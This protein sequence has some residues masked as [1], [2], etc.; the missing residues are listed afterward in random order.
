ME[1]NI[2]TLSFLSLTEVPPGS[3]AC[4]RPPYSAE[5]DILVECDD[6]TS[7]A[8][9]ISQDIVPGYTP[10][11]VPVVLPA[12]GPRVCLVTGKLTVAFSDGMKISSRSTKRLCVV[13]SVS[14]DAG[15]KVPRLDLRIVD[16]DLIVGRVHPGDQTSFRFCLENNDPK[17]T[18]RGTLD[19]LS[20]NN[21]RRPADESDEPPAP[22]HGVFAISD[23]GEGDDFPLAFRDDLGPDC[24]RLPAEPHNTIRPTIARDIVLGPGEKEIVEIVM[25]PWG[26]CANGSCGELLLTLDGIYSDDTDALA[27]S[28]AIIAADTETDPRYVWPDSGKVASLQSTRTG[29]QFLAEP[30]PDESY[31]ILFEQVSLAIGHNGEPVPFDASTQP[32]PL[33]PEHG[34][35]A[36]TVDVEP[37]GHMF[38]SFFDIDVECRGQASAGFETELISMDLVGELPS[39][40]PMAMGVI[41]VTNTETKADSFFDVFW[42]VNI[43]AQTQ[44]PNGGTTTVPTEIVSM[45]LSGNVSRIRLRVPPE[46][47]KGI[48]DLVVVGF[49][50]REDFRGF[51]RKGDPEPCPDVQIERLQCTKVGDFMVLTWANNPPG[52]ACEK[53][54]IRDDNGVIA[55]LPPDGTSYRIPCAELDASGTLCV[56]CVDATGNE[57][58]ACCR[59]SCEDCPK[60]ET[61][62]QVVDDVVVVSWNEISEDCCLRYVL[63]VDGQVVGTAPAGTT[64]VRIPCAELPSGSGTI[65]VYCV[66]ENGEEVQVSCCEYECPT[67]CP[68][69]RVDCAVVDGFVVLQWDQIP[70]TCCSR[71]VFS[72]GG[73]IL[74]S[75]LNDRNSIR[76]PCDALPEPS[77]EICITCIDRNGE[78]IDKAC[79]QYECP[80]DPCPT[81]RVDCAGIRD[82]VLVQWNE[83]GTECCDRFII[84]VEDRIVGTAPAGTTQFFVPCDELPVRAGTI[85]VTCVDENGEEVETAC[86]N[87]ICPNI[88]PCPPL[89]ADCAVVDDIVVIQWDPMPA[90]CCDRFVISAGGQ[91]LAVLPSGSTAFRIPCAD[92]PAPSGEICVTC[93][94]FEGEAVETVCCEYE[95]PQDPCPP[96]RA[97]C[98]VV[99]DVVVVSW[100]EVPEDCC[101]RFVLRV[102]DTVVGTAPAGTTT[103]R[104]PCD[105][106]PEASGTICVYC[107]DENGAEVD[108]ACCDY[109]CEEEC[110]PLRVACSVIDGTLIVRWNVLPDDCCS[111]YR[112]LIDGEAV[113]SVPA[114]V[115]AYRIRCEDLENPTGTVCVVCVDENGEVQDRA[116]CDYDCGEGEC[117]ELEVECFIINGL[118]KVRWNSIPEECC[119]RFIVRIDGQVV[120]VLPAG[121]TE[122]RIPCVDLPVSAGEVCVTCVAPN[123]E[124][125]DRACCDFECPDD[126]CP[127]LE[128]L[129]CRVIDGV[130]H[131]GWSPIPEACCERIIIRM[132]GGEDIAIL[133]GSATSISIPCEELPAESGTIC[134]VCVA[135]NGDETRACCE[136]SC[137]EDCPPVKILRCERTDGG[138]LSLVWEQMPEGCCERIFIRVNGQDIAS[139]PGDATEF[140]IACEE[141]PEESGT[142]CVVC[143]APDGTE[144]EACCEYNCG[145]GWQRP[146]DC[147]Q[148]GSTNITDPLCVLG[149]LFAGNPTVAGCG[150]IELL[151]W[152]G[153]ASLNI[154]DAIAALNHL[155]GGGA[156]HVLGPIERCVLVEGCPDICEN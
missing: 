25:R 124:E 129:R 98:A 109:S 73:V 66:D 103:V 75:I 17:E 54:E 27:C 128:I 97:T 32:Q 135:P 20:M 49:D 62:C 106:L 151:D 120:G 83:R 81:L 71:F 113:A 77:G 30:T 76:F 45:E 84:R 149:F 44:N 94:N 134:V 26:M 130:L 121:N 102:G 46:P 34:R 155:F 90:F 132:Q 150:G 143:R 122:F 107:V 38:D 11:A 16:P 24:I 9:S 6:G 117:P 116:C 131:L 72:S 137:Q 85:C 144:T 140:G 31:S 125:V 110:P 61:T 69:L 80:V 108:R 5:I 52:C 28:S 1:I 13:D 100:N 89:R 23:P 56:V 40:A 55:V 39:L 79:C 42:Q 133:P 7:T 43:D 127:P 48:A 70:A 33:T 51:A 141:L 41:K 154:G 19:A 78:E 21:S 12:G 68:P 148:D 18:F 74:D 142:I 123:G 47:I 59:Y 88:E 118:L 115:N 60:L 35:L 146:F 105:E 104:I 87:F 64:T 65:C 136:Y 101:T 99:D 50:I 58:E 147:N 156:Q 139:L 92:L 114:G 126:P 91:Q 63:R 86:C 95:C 29:L 57:S 3:G 53:I 145:R 111:T 152:N 4:P 138:H 8:A 96:L 153:D 93:V 36:T 82:G 15:R 112:I 14:D 67:P 119:A 2:A 10:I 37:T 22:G